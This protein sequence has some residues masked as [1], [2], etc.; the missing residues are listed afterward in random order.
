[1][2]STCQEAN[3]SCSVFMVYTQPL[4]SWDCRHHKSRPVMAAIC[5][6]GV[7]WT[8]KGARYQIMVATPLC[9]VLIMDFAAGPAIKAIAGHLVSIRRTDVAATSVA[10]D[11][12]VQRTDA[13]AQGI[14]AALPDMTS[15][16]GIHVAQK[17]RT[18]AKQVTISSMASQRLSAQV[19]GH[20]GVA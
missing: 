8:S 6:E 3:S 19:T 10:T 12:R 14:A 13:R 20:A 16:G 15:L 4:N 17:G 7:A 11:V 18:M 9:R 1:M 2:A 5:K